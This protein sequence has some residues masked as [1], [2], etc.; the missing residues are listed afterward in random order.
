[1]LLGN[2]YDV[3]SLGYGNG[4]EIKIPGRYIDKTVD[5]TI[6]KNDSVI[7]G[8]GVK[9]VMSNYKQNSNNYFENMLGE[10]ANLRSN[11]IPYFQIFI[12]P[13]LIPYFDKFGNIRSW[14]KINE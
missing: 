13:E 2:D 12:L 1:M 6:S 8:I 10:T 5:I 14:E 9:F 3:H 7:A 11:N 4:K